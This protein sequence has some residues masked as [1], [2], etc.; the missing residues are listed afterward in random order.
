MLVNIGLVIKRF[1][2]DV[3][4]EWFFASVC[5]LVCCEIVGLLETFTTVFTKIHLARLQQ[6]LMR[7]FKESLPMT[8]TWRCEDRLVCLWFHC[9]KSVT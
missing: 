2:T 5:P 1:P 4:R 7:H 9:G 3:T 8:F 6:V